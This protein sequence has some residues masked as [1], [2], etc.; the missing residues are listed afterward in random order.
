MSESKQ[1][2]N[3]PSYRIGFSGRSQR[4]FMLYYNALQLAN[5][6]NQGNMKILSDIANLLN[7]TTEKNN[8]IL[9]VKLQSVTSDDSNMI[10]KL[11][12]KN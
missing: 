9:V 1:G 10:P 2:C 7:K 4:D 11:E 5:D 3:T 8:T 12:F 6:M